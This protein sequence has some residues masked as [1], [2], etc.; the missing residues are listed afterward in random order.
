MNFFSVSKCK[1]SSKLNK[2]PR[3]KKE[4]SPLQT[5]ILH[6]ITEL[7][8]STESKLSRIW[9]QKFTPTFSAKLRL[10]FTL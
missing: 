4:R 1:T 2:E 9:L 6:F 7:Q 5:S 10:T 8:A 3:Y